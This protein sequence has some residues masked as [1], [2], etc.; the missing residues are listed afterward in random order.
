MNFKKSN[1][2]LGTDDF[3]IL[4][5]KWLT[6]YEKTGIKYVILTSEQEYSSYLPSTV[7]GG[8]RAPTCQWL[9]RIASLKMWLLSCL[10]VSRHH[11]CLPPDGRSLTGALCQGSNPTWQRRQQRAS[12]GGQI[13]AARAKSLPGEKKGAAFSLSQTQKDNKWKKIKKASS[14]PSFNFFLK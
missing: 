13:N 6:L 9:I 1:A 12:R 3:Y 11:T 14:S 8:G 10:C 5:L 7:S 2:V 4:N